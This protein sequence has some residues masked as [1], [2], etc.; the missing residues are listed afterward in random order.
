MAASIPGGAIRLHGWLKHG[1]VQDVL[2][3]SHVLGFPSIR[4]FGGG[5]VLEAMAV[6]VVPMVVDYAGPAELVTPQTGF[7]IAL[8][9]R[10]SIVQGVR[11]QLSSAASQR[12]ELRR[13]S[14]AG[15]ARVASHF[16]WA[17]KASQVLRVY[18]WVLRGGEKPV[19]M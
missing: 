14:A 9:D 3:S 8:G 4:E 12:G 13:M 7:K 19:L 18:D 10:E 15:R 17:A 5:V 1:Q 2:A 16:T 6:G 11:A